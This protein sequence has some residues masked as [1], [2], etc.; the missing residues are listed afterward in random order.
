M[1]ATFAFA[2][3]MKDSG[4]VRSVMTPTLMG[5]LFDVVIVVPQASTAPWNCSV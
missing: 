2:M 3:P 4:P 5:S 1:S